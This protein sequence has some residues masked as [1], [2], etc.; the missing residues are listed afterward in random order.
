MRTLFTALA[1]SAF[2]VSASTAQY[3]KGRIFAGPMVGLTGYET[4]LGFGAMGEYAISDGWSA[5]LA[6]G[7]TNFSIR[8]TFPPGFEP[9]NVP[10]IDYTIVS[11][12]GFGAYHFRPF[13]T[14]DPFL[15]G[16]LGYNSW[17][18]KYLL[19]GKPVDIPPGFSPVYKSGVGMALGAGARYHFN[20]LISGRLT[21]GYPFL[22]GLGVDVAFGEPA[23]KKDGDTVLPKP[24]V[25]DT[26]PPKKYPL[27]VGLYINGKASIKTEVAKGWKTGPVFNTPPDFGV[28][29]MA[30]FGKESTVGFGLD[31]GSSSYGYIMKP[32]SNANDSNTVQE[33]FQYFNVF[34]HLN[35]SGFII[36]VNWGFKTNYT[37]YFVNGDTASMVGQYVETIQSGKVDT[38]VLTPNPNGPAYDPTKYV[39]D[40]IEIRI[41]GSIP[42]VDS[43]I[44]RLSLNVMAGYTLTGMFIDYR[45]YIGSY[46]LVQDPNDYTKLK[47]GDPEKTFNPVIPSLSVGVQWYFKIGL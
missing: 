31:L 47:R 42:I 37:T 16:G 20:D 38:T 36:G 13:E 34:P 32:E 39:A 41:G 25:V 11:I 35:V 9:A 3:S 14:I 19:D 8:S 6:L 2:C 24:V 10:S 4:S 29:I 30:P 15:Y 26:A 5:G 23:V 44:G 27:H 21:V 12:I 43:D 18:F 46:P 17:N 40:I 28:S 22:V 45:N 1:I 7:Y 33:R